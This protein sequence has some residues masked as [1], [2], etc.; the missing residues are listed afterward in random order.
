MSIP[1]LWAPETSSLNS[2]HENSSEVYVLMTFVSTSEYYGLNTMANN[3]T[4][5]GESL[6]SDKPSYAEIIGV[7]TLAAR[8]QLPQAIAQ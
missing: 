6:L 2:F 8:T 1:P 5:R 7:T 4:P 3:G